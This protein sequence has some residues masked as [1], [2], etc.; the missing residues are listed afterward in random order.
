MLARMQPIHE[1][2]SEIRWN[3]H[4]RGEFEIAFADHE[5]PELQRVPIRQ[6][7]FTD[8]K[9]AFEFVNEDDRLL[10]IPLHRIRKV[11]RNHELIWSRPD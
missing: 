10:T 9:F 6:M 5:K 4:I 7:R 3:P 8:S 11:Y 1:L 2:L